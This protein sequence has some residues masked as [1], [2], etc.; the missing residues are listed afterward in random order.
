MFVCNYAPILKIITVCF[1]SQST[2]RNFIESVTCGKTTEVKYLIRLNQNPL[3]SYRRMK[4]K[5]AQNWCPRLKPL[6]LGKMN[7]LA[8]MAW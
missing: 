6:G 7:Q 1:N 3:E 8:I 4:F 5:P 2:I